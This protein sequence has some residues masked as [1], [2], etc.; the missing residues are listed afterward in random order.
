M[1]VT[2]DKVNNTVFDIVATFKAIYGYLP[3]HIP[4]AGPQPNNVN[5]YNINKAAVKKTVTATGSPLYGLADMIGREVFMPITLTANGVNYDF[6]FSI[7]GL[8]NQK[9]MKE[10]SM[11]ERGGV[12]IEEI[13]SGAWEISLKGFLI[14]ANDQFPDDQLAALNTLYMTDTPVYLK[15]AL[16]DIFLGGNDQVV[17][18]NLDIPAKAKVIGVRDFS[19][20]MVQDSILDLYLVQ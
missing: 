15:C 14:D 11:I 8:K 20:N 18:K 9:S 10:T 3:A 12:V 1:G 17:I 2:A 13:S 16:S 19:F 7:I 4:E 6:P 5:P